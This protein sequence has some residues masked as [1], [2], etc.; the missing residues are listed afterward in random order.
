MQRRNNPI[1][2]AEGEAE[3][4]TFTTMLERFLVHSDRHGGHRRPDA[5]KVA[6]LRLREHKKTNALLSG[7][8]DCARLATG[9]APV[10]P[11]DAEE[12]S[13]ASLADE[14]SSV[15]TDSSSSS[16][17]SSGGS[18]N[19]NSNPGAPGGEEM[20]VDDDEDENDGDE[21]DED[22]DENDDENGWGGV[23]DD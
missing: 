16:S 9:L 23:G 10:A 7:L 14:S 20:D 5:A 13:D 15:T 11:E 22:D 8:L 6:E 1:T 18:G 3:Q 12:D 4:K 19:G 17:S 21:N 2:R